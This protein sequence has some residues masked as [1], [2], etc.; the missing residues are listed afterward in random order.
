LWYK[1]SKFCRLVNRLPGPRP[2]PLIGSA[3]D[4]VG[5]CD[6]K[7]ECHFHSRLPFKVET[8]EAIR[9]ATAKLKYGF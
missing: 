7:L 3:L 9:S 8:D 2:L 1:F 4:V 5:G 6:G